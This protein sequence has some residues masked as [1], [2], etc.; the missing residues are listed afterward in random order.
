MVGYLLFYESIESNHFSLQRGLRS[1]AVRCCLG[2]QG[3]DPRGAAVPM[4][5]LLRLLA[6]P[7]HHPL[8]AL[9]QPRN[10]LPQRLDQLVVR[11]G[12]VYHHLQQNED[13]S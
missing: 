9:S 8:Q 10:L 3:R 1:A 11:V 7:L 4:G 5:P 13:V 12:F 6:L 2:E